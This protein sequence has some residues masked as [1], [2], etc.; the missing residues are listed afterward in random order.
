V[1]ILA[2]DLIAFGPF[3][4]ASL[5]L[6]A[7]R[8]GLHVV[9]GPNEAGKSATLR[10]LRA[11]F[12]GIPVRTADNFLH[13]NK[14]LRIG[15]RIQHSDGTELELTRRKGAKNTLLDDRGEPLAE[16]VLRRFLGSVEEEVFSKVF[17]IS[18]EDLVR[19]GEELI[20]GGGETGESLFAAA[21]GGG[22]LHQV[23]VDLENEAEELFRPR[24]STKVINKEIARYKEASRAAVQVSLS[25]REWEDHRNAL[26]DA[27]RE[28]Q[29][30]SGQL[31]ALAA[32]RN[33][34]E[35]IREALPAV[36]VG[37]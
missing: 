32:E 33:R 21:V 5:D 16:G 11:L 7:G 30:V 23:L 9:Y 18:H 24:A 36:G 37:G 34:L 20:V 6:A 17:G 29:E 4:G 3:H 19:G 22:G 13:D 12:Y 35:R 10:A 28:R 8:E 14:S 15:G 31:R 2:V 27:Q 1:K 25:S 26:A